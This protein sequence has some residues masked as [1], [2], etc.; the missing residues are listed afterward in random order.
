MQKFTTRAAADKAA[1]L[2][3][4]ADVWVCAYDY[5]IGG[6]LF[7]AT[8]PRPTNDSVRV[9]SHNGVSEYLAEA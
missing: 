4:A 3:T 8:G 6:F 9:L 5:A 2:T 7:V 1:A